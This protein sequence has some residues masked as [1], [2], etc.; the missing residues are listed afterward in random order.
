MSAGEG[1]QSSRGPF[2]PLSVS[3]PWGGGCRV[4]VP[5]CWAG[6]PEG[7][8]ALAR[9]TQLS[10]VAPWEWGAG[11]Q[12]GRGQ[13]RVPGLP[14]G[15]LADLLWG[16]G[17]GRGRRGSGRGQG[18][19]WVLLGGQGWLYRGPRARNPAEPA[20]P[21]QQPPR[22][23]RGTA[24]DFPKGSHGEEGQRGRGHRGAGEL[25]QGP[26]QLP[27]RVGDPRGGGTSPKV[28]QPFTRGRCCPWVMQMRSCRGPP[29]SEYSR[30]R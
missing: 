11:E 19:R 23:E 26:S 9:E 2:E 28:P 1:C 12:L 24:G 14:G 17:G 21:K 3:F 5:G 29:Q 18:P 25:E 27:W 10:L 30:F 8:A 16:G 7:A 4:A 22:T 6:R 20:P 15:G 13:R